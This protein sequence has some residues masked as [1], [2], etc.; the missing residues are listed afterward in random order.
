M[1]PEAERLRE[2]ALLVRAAEQ[3]ARRQAARMRGDTAA[4]RAAENELRELWRAH[5]DLERVA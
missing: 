2:Q 1:R 3:E 4:E 5:A